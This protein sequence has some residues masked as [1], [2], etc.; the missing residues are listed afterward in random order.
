ML[1]TLT[2]GKHPFFQKNYVAP[3]QEILD[4]P[5]MVDDKYAF[6]SDLPASM[7]KY[8]NGT[9]ASVM[10]MTKE[11]RHAWK[12]ENAERKAAYYQKKAEAFRAKLNRN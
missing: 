11:E 7:K 5:F 9:K 6:Y 12:L 3:K 4:K 1:G 8:K 10:M 2:N